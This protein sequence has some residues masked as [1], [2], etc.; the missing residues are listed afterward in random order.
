VS[1]WYE[2]GELIESFFGTDYWYFV[3][4]M[5]ALFY[6]LIFCKEERKRL[7]IPA[8]AITIFVLNPVTHGILE[9][10]YWYWRLLWMLPMVPV[11]A[12]AIIHFIKLI[13]WKGI[14]YIVFLLLLGCI[15]I[16]GHP[17][18]RI[19]TDPFTK[20]ENHFKIPQKAIN[21]ANKLLEFSDEPRAVMPDTLYCYIRQYT[22][23][24]HLMYGRDA[25]GFIAKG[26]MS[27][28]A[29]Q[30]YEQMCLDEPNLE[31]VFGLARKN[32]YE[33]VVGRKRQTFNPTE[34]QKN[35]FE[36][37]AEVGNYLIYR[38]IGD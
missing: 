33:F 5:V 1:S 10:L 19:E 25:E 6:L 20:A 8:L 36:L 15:A 31:I 21:V 9:D 12:V 38:D 13:K 23:K 2:I 24:I 28:D 29:K 17:V 37:A 30:I 3:I 11:V 14:G 26:M 32:G 27:E 22:T 35:G 4:Y 16:G 7:A 34:V 18:Y